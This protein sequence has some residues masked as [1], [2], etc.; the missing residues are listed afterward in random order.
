MQGNPLHIIYGL[1]I[2]RDPRLTLTMDANHCNCGNTGNRKPSVY[3]VSANLCNALIV[4]PNE[5]RSAT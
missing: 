2:P 5:T 4:S 3:A 1:P